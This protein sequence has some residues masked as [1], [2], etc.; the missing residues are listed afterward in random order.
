MAKNFVVC[1]HKFSSGVQLSKFTA[2]DYGPDHFNPFFPAIGK[3]ILIADSDSIHHHSD[4]LIKLSH[5]F[6][7]QP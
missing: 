6:Y 1:K 7:G 3:N 2:I 5:G 4:G